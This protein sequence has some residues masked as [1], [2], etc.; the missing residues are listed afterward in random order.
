LRRSD[1][2][3]TLLFN[4]L[5]SGELELL[6]RARDGML[7]RNLKGVNGIRRKSR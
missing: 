3:L 7:L 6:S 1:H 5:Q 4:R 2:N